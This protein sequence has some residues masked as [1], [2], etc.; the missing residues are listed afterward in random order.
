MLR[1]VAKLGWRTWRRAR[2]LVLLLGFLLP[3][4]AATQSL[5]T[6]DEA[7]LPACCRSHGKHKCS[8]GYLLVAS[9]A[10]GRSV[11]APHISEKC[12]CNAPNAPV[13]FGDHHARP[14]EIVQLRLQLQHSAFQAMSGSTDAR[15]IATA[16]RQR[17]PP[18]PANSPEVSSLAAVY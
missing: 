7:T 12:P 6:D 16:N 5:S 17:G 11:S 3:F 1:T 4:I 2:A 9:D 15:E 8:M 13:L 14:V 18:F 10:H